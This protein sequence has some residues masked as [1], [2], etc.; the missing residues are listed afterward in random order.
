MSHHYLKN[1]STRTTSQSEAIPGT[2]QV[3]NSAGG[4]AWKMDDWKRLNRWLILGSESGTYYI[5]EK[6]LTKENADVVLRCIKED[7]PKTVQTIIDISKAGRAPKN[8]PAIFA[9]AMC[10]SLGD[11]E[12]RRCAA[13]ALND[14]CRIG[15][16]LF[17][18]ASYVEQFR[19]WGRILKTAIAAWYNAKNIDDLAYQVVKYR[20]R[21]G[22]SHRDLLRLSHPKGGKDSFYPSHHDIYDW[23]A[24]KEDENRGISA[25]NIPFIG[26]FEQIQKLDKGDVDQAAEFISDY[27][28][29]REAV[30]T[31][32]LNS[33]LVWEALLEKMPMTA[34][35]RNLG[36]MSKIGLLTNMSDAATTVISRLTNEEL[37]RKARVHPI[38]ILAAMLTYGQGRGMRGHGKWTPVAQVVDALDKAF[39]LSF[40]NVESTGKRILLALDVSGSMC[41]PTIANVPG[42]TPR[43]GSAALALV[44]AAVEPNHMIVAFSCKGVGGWTSPTQSSMY[45]W[46]YSSSNGIS[47]LSISPRQRLDDVIKIADTLPFGGT[48]CALPM[49]YALEK[50]LKIDAFVTL[51]DS[52][53]WAGTP[54]PTQ[55]LRQYR[56]KTGI[57]AKNI[58]VGM[59][60]S[61]FSINDPTDPNGLDIVGFSTDTPKVISTFIKEGF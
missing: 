54:H 56:E 9:L 55:A 48:D 6:T 36:N 30:P 7:G 13:R 28:L 49:L 25:L 39:Y 60:S 37:I 17:H 11:T 26:A 10:I 19:G 40:G 18:F 45:N 61:D 21:D 16:H 2:D 23:I 44:T 3:P 57:N 47:P 22:W 43:V 58:I 41:G 33:K 1:Y 50:G 24:G 34:M 12:T 29:P 8:D 4:F 53:T 35:I 5:T 27:N 51:T 46:G 52:E 20:Q 38:Q 59:T 15:T 32:L 42:L 14:V 31:E